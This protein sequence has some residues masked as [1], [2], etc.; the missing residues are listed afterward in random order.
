[1][2]LYSYEEFSGMTLS[3]CVLSDFNQ[4]FS[5]LI[6]AIEKNMNSYVFDTKLSKENGFTL[7]YFKSHINAYN[8]VKSAITDVELG[9]FIRCVGDKHLGIDQGVLRFYLGA[10]CGFSDDKLLSHSEALVKT[11]RYYRIIV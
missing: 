1:M 8:K 4:F 6:G 2:V 9:D 3:E 5:E 7:D 10:R 11:M